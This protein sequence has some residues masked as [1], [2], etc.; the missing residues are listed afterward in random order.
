[1]TVEP[2]LKALLRDRHVHE[3]QVFVAEYRRIARKLELPRSAEPPSKAAYYHWL[4]GQM[5][6]LPQGYHCLV[7]ETMF[8]GWTAK[9]LFTRSERRRARAASGG[10][11]ASITPSVDPAQ[12]AGLWCTGFM[13]EGAHHVD[14]STITVTNGVVT[15]RNFPP[16]PRTEGQKVGFHNDISLHLSGRH[17]IGQWRNTSDSYYYGSVHLAVLPGET[18]LDGYYT[19]VLNDTQVAADRWRWVRV[20]TQSAAGIDLH[21]LALGEPQHLYNTLLEHAQYGP[22]I[23]LAQLTEKS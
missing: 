14:L 13:F 5:K 2:T 6:G 18:I 15:V 11:L 4:S 10:L 9:E 17:L 3:Y 16:A 12:L 8:P 7:L 21:T 22:A 19:S 20:E 23:A 1:M